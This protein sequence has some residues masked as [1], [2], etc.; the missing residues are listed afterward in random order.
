VGDRPRVGKTLFNNQQRV[1]NAHFLPTNGGLAK[2]WWVSKIFT[3]TTYD[4][5][6]RGS[7][8]PLLPTHRQL[9]IMNHGVVSVYRVVEHMHP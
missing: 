4:D 8:K 1:G 7:V 5:S 3:S 9:L 6:R 2:R